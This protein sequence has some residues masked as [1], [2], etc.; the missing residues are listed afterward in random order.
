MS[1]TEASADRRRERRLLLWLLGVALVTV[2]V[3]IGSPLFGVRAFHASD[4]VLNRAPW[5]SFAP[6]GFEVT[7][8][9]VSDT[10]DGYLP[11]HAELRRQLFE[12]TFPMWTTFPSGGQPLGSVPDDGLLSPMNLPYWI[13]PLWYAPGLAKL[14]ELCVA[15][16]FTFLFL[17]RIGL[18]RPAGIVGGLIYAF[19]GF[20]VVWTNWPQTHVG[21]LIPALFWAIELALD[22]RTL[23]SALPI[24][25]VTA[26]ML[27][28]GFP[29][30]TGYAL[31]AA[32]I[33]AV[34]RLAAMRE[35]EV[36]PRV[37][38][39]AI[40]A[41]AVLVGVGLTALEIL[42]FL[43]RIGTIDLGYRQQTPADHLP[44]R[45]LLTLA[46]P[47]AFGSP[48]D[49]T[50]FGPSSYV[51]IQSF[52]GAS[53]LVLVAAGAARFR[54]LKVARGARTYL[55]GGLA[56]TGV[57]IYVGGP[58]LGAMQK[59]PP[60]DTNAVGRLRSVF[61]FF[62]AALA[63]LGLQAVTEPERSGSR[64]TARIVWAAAGALAIGG[65]LWAWRL[66]AGEHDYLL[67]HAVVPL[68]AGGLTAAGVVWSG[69]AG[70][71]GRRVI[72]WAVPVL[73]AVEAL[74]FAV[75]FWPRIPVSE[76][77]P[78][79]STHRFLLEH[80]GED[81]VASGGVALSPGTTTYYGLRALTAHTFDEPSW[82]DLLLAVD[83]TAFD[84][85]PTF[86]TLGS[87]S[88]VAT[89]PI[90]D[91]MAVRYFVTAPDSGVLGD[92]VTVS[93]PVG[94]VTMQ[95]GSTLTATI[96][97]GPIR[98]VVVHL[99]SDP[100]FSGIA[101]LDAQVLDAKGAV[102][103]SGRRRLLSA[104]G[105]G[106]LAVPIVEADATRA[107]RGSGPLT[108]RL[109]LDAEGGQLVLG[110]DRRGDPA[111]QVVLA[112]DDGLRV[113]FGDGAI[114]YERERALPRIRWASHAEVIT[115]PAT[116]IATLGSSI[117]PDTVVL[118]QPGP[119]GSGAPAKLDVLED[120]DTQIRV[121][122]DAG[123]AGYLV[124]AD[125]LQDG[126]GAE[127]DGRPAQLR[128]ADH[129]GVAV[130]VPAGTHEVTVR[131]Q[132]VGWQPGKAISA[133]SLVLV[134]GIGLS[135]LLRRSSPAP[136]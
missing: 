7:N 93:K 18:D 14:I 60:F 53:A 47:N 41:G 119:P 58:L 109:S 124:I 135:G 52:I 65:A 21:A 136:A 63:A 117:P 92:V 81:R 20:Q 118:S 30:V 36:A 1:R 123:G 87:S 80:I 32:G 12:G 19:S 78:T 120:G 89:S 59:L 17:R 82:R 95:A 114:V 26:V 126:W 40:L 56:F 46:I 11:M 69:R 105:T 102:L 127:V 54:D 94:T 116:R 31:I 55:W 91:R 8:P 107:G 22:R 16:G 73:V 84:K 77:Y 9:L 75:P 23:R 85:S 43:H 34:V 131:Y 57:L 49:R 103:T 111:V 129:A 72:V 132:P 50:Y 83:P 35:E 128:A 66:A 33:Y 67:R 110:A 125:A 104:E 48:V 113:V 62:L 133:V 4:L 27:F 90:L 100:V 39:A 121:S 51:E 106:D 86:P 71:R 2:V 29:S 37:R 10:V 115:D 79:T 112:P 6:D 15:V 96:P 101:F 28:E 97:R 45:T 74:A 64:R 3:A 99:Q 24:S 61:G 134:I 108:V 70:A 98:A 25:V 76:F 68:V 38:T 42:P 130:L 13:V 44:L 5:R 88:E 122:V